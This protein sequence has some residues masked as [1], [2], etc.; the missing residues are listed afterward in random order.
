[1]PAAR[2]AAGRHV[3]TVETASVHQVLFAH[4][5]IRA[6]THAVIEENQRLFSNSLVGPVDS[7]PSPRNLAVS[8][9]QSLGD[10]STEDHR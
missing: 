2:A 7:H 5:Q 8:G 1:M 3:T 4:L 6:I 10:R 9:R